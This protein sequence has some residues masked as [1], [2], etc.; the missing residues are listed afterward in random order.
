MKKCT[1]I[2]AY[3]D[4][5]IVH[6]RQQCDQILN[7]PNL[8]SAFQKEA[9]KRKWKTVSSKEKV[10]LLLKKVISCF[11]IKKPLFTGDY[12][13][14]E[15]IRQCFQDMAI[16]CNILG[17]TSKLMFDRGVTE[18]KKM[19]RPLW[20]RDWVKNL[21]NIVSEQRK[22][23]ALMVKTLD[24][25]GLEQVVKLLAMQFRLNGIEVKVFCTHCGGR[26]AKEL[27]DSG[28]EVIEFHNNKA[29]FNN[30]LKEKTPLLINT[31]FASDFYEIIAKYQ[32]PI[33]EVIHN[34]Y[35]FLTDKQ[36][37]TEKKKAEY[38]S[39]YIAV[40]ETAKEVFRHKIPQVS[41][42]KI[43]VIGNSVIKQE[44]PVCRRSEV[45]KKY[46]VSEGDF[47]FLMAGSID[48]RKNQIGVLRAL[49]MVR[50]LTDQKIFL[51]LAG[52]E[53]DPEYK[54][55]LNRFMVDCTLQD[56]VIFLGYTNRI[57]EIMGASDVLIMDSYYEGWS[58]AATEALLCGIPLI[59][60]ECGS[61]KELVAGGEN[62]ILI[63]NPIKNIFSI[64]SVDLYDMM[65]M[66]KNENI[67]ELVAAMLSI[68]KNRIS[69]KKSQ[70]EIINYA[71]S[72]F[73]VSNMLQQYA[74]IFDESCANT[75]G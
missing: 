3:E 26:T 7:C 66:G 38:I 46:G 33:V 69:W 9:F 45:R 59:H 58:M 53:T 2:K 27:Q 6:K 68:L 40:S 49:D 32:I 15:D 50:Y 47:V 19:V 5:Y 31:H 70:N 41:E 52:A 54:E 71:E 73:S 4:H 35:V 12:M 57:S 16:Y 48:A 63:S 11:G 51:F 42:D 25:G 24:S 14:E 21:G 13:L 62:G 23:I 20:T 8:I 37:E 75:C 60:S 30:Y 56:N 72:H 36:L 39:H 44:S 74:K 55:K 1:D 10:K 67:A 17:A 34:M 43:T 64:N 28:I 61:G 65:H 18:K 29:L 22:Y